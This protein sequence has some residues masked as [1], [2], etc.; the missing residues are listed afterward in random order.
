[1]GTPKL[2]GQR[3]NSSNVPNDQLPVN[4]SRC[5]LADRPTLPLV[6]PYARDSVLV[7]REQLGFALRAPTATTDA[8]DAPG[9]CILE[10]VESRAV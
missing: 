3:G 2:S 9:I 7:H 1:M 10:G 5:D 6:R 8:G 4:A